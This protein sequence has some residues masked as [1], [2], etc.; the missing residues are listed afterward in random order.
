LIAPHRSR[1]S[2]AFRLW[3][4][5]HDHDACRSRSLPAHHSDCHNHQ[6][7]GRRLWRHRHQPAL[8]AQKAATGH[9]G[10]LMPD[11]VLSVVS[12]ILTPE[13]KWFLR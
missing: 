2:G 3:G 7:T 12:L 6:R 8:C 9:G 4:P 11:A 5:V 13:R 1:R 10:T